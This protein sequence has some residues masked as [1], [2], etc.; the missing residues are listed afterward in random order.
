MMMYV[1]QQPTK[2]GEATAAK[3]DREDLTSYKSMATGQGQS[4]NTYA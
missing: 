4:H 2:P 3:A 1:L